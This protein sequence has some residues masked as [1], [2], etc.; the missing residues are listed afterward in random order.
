MRWVLN[1]HT[2]EVSELNGK[3]LCLEDQCKAFDDNAN[4]VLGTV[5]SDIQDLLSHV[6]R[7]RAEFDALDIN[8]D[9]A[10]DWIV[11]LECLTNAQDDTIKALTDHLNSV[12]GRL[13]HCSSKGKGREVEVESAPGVL[14][15][16]IDLADSSD[17]DDEDL[18][19]SYHTPPGGRPILSTA[20]TLVHTYSDMSDQEGP[21]IGYQHLGSPGEDALVENTI[22]IP[23]RVPGVTT[24]QSRLNQ[25]LAVGRQRAVRSKGRPHSCYSPYP[26]VLQPI[27]IG[28]HCLQPCRCCEAGNHE[29]SVSW[30]RQNSSASSSDS[31]VGEH[32]F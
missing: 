17:R 12:E 15:S 14:G 27:E 31:E 26:G 18:L 13:C 11:A 1:T 29:G 19:D 23:I 30:L 10:L 20:L 22:P 32:A 6:D 8:L 4:K 5:E 28:R 21:G 3:V 25:L 24:D 7:C 16:F 9:M 2:H